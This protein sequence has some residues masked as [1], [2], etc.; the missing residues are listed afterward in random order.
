[1][2]HLKRAAGGHLLRTTDGHLVN[3][4]ESGGCN[5]CS[6]PLP[7]TLYMTFAGLGGDFAAYNGKHT[8]TWLYE[9]RWQDAGLHVNLNYVNLAGV[10]WYAQLWLNGTCIKDWVQGDDFPCEPL[11]A[12]HG[13]VEY[14]CTQGG[15]LDG[16]SC[17]LS[18]GATCVV[19]LT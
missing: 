10:Y 6:P 18:I 9:C 11:S 19:S 8:L 2:G 15:C 4:C 1:M 3:E 17:S 12:D 14:T 5:A 16:N 13:Y 7:D